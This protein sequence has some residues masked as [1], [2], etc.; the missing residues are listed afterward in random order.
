MGKF[1]ME[2]SF[3]DIF[4]EARIGIVVA[5]GIDNHRRED[6]SLGQ[7][8]AEANQNALAFIGQEPFRDNPAVL[9]WR[10]AFQRFRTKKGARCSIEAML[11][12]IKNGGQIASINPLVDVYN[13]VSLTYGFPCGGEDLDR[14]QGSLRLTV[15]EGG[16][17][18]L[19][20]GS[21]EEDPAL[22]G[23][24]IYRDEEGAVCRCWNWRESQRTMLTEQTRNAFLCLESVA[25]QQDAEFSEAARSLSGLVAEHLQGETALYFLCREQKQIE[26]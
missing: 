13:A 6:P 10:E 25:P 11:K 7:L 3:W 14:F 5:R 24:V 9:V 18:F 19:P 17:T 21:E 16:E 1:I 4:P 26:F 20:L 2:E 22:P 23:E 12:R 8:L 15:A